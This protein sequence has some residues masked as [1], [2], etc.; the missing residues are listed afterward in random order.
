[1]VKK[2]LPIKAKK[3]IKILLLALFLLGIL[4]WILNFKVT[5]YKQLNYVKYEVKIPLYAKIAGFLYRDSQY[6]CLVRQITQDCSNNQEKVLAIF[7]WTNQNIRKEIP[8]GWPIID[9][10]LWDVIVRGYGTNDQAAYVFSVLC[11]YAGIPA[12]VK[13]IFAKDRDHSI[14]ISLVCLG[15]R[16][17]VFDV[18]YGN[19]FFNE[20]NVLASLDDLI[21]NPKLITQSAPELRISGIP[22]LEYF[23]NLSSIKEKDFSRLKLQM[24]IERFFYEVKSFL[25]RGNK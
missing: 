6:R 3:L 22:Y 10:H 7:K 2:S 8:D 23:Y 15:K 18:Y 24:P 4:F 21:R 19:Y 12:A 9:E 25:R 1:M 14:V 13:R 16:E 20:S 17:I 11:S 5:Y